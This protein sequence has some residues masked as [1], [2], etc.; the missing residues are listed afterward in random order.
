MTLLRKKD[1]K[2]IVPFQE[3]SGQQISKYTT[4]LAIDQHQN[5]YFINVCTVLGAFYSLSLWKLLNQLE[6]LVN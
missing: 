4:L 6:H 1:P 2:S 5:H 3:A